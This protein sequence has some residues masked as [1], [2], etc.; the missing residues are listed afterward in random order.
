ML[1]LSSDFAETVAGALIGSGDRQPPST[2]VRV[3]IIKP[4]IGESEGLGHL[5][6]GRVY[7]VPAGL[8]SY[9]VSEKF[10]IFERRSEDRPEKR[11]TPDRRKKR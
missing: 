9:L 8:A 3:L 7:D 1:V 4:P 6:V 10:A 11:P 5:R 2:T